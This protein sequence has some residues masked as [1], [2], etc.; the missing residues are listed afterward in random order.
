MDF[1][2]TKAQKILKKSCYEFAQKELAPYARERQ[3][4]GKWPYDVWDK[5]AELG[6][7]GI[8]VPEEYGGG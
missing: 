6:F 5:L 4:S 2:L 7:T 3:E 8:V 1:E